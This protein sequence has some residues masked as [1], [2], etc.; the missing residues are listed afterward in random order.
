ME[1]ATLTAG[2]HTRSLAPQCVRLRHDETHVAFDSAFLQAF[3]V[4]LSKYSWPAF[5][6]VDIFFSK[7][8]HWYD[9]GGYGLTDTFEKYTD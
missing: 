9:Q 7:K 6:H 1:V 2:R 4:I 3:L 5:L 8:K